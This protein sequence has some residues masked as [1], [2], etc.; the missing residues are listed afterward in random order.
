MPF[1]KVNSIN[2][3]Y[4]LQ[5]Q[6]KPLVFL[7]GYTGSHE[8]WKNQVDILPPGNMSLAVDHRGHGRTEAPKNEGEYSI[9]IFS[10]DIHALLRTLNIDQCCLVGHSMGG[11][12][13]LQFVLDHPEMVRALILV[14]TSSGDF[15][16]AP[17]FEEL[18][19]KLDEL[20]RNEGMEAAFEYDAAN[21]PVRI[22]RFKKHPELKEITRR[23]VLNTSVDG[24]IYVARTFG[25]WPSVTSRLSEIK[26]PTIIFLGEED[27]GFV[28]ASQ[29]LKDNIPSS[30]LI[31][32]PGAGHS[33]HEEA[34][35]LFN[36]ALLD[37][38]Q[39]IEY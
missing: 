35:D 33:P 18:R 37:F 13:S 27:A 38:L 21:N 22:E 24:Y 23:K 11:F 39:K 1:A 12:M 19:A 29:T 20:A 16:R 28:K 8:D 15:E 2:L 4:E 30:E 6:G 36:K 25:K 3:Y 7:H 32:I 34:P 17:G 14:D 31:T 9:K 26:A 10:E 5:G